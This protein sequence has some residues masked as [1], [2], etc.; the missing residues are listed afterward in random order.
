M[1]RAEI[2]LRPNVP[3]AAIERTPLSVSQRKSRMESQGP[4]PGHGGKADFGSDLDC[5]AGASEPKK[6]LASGETFL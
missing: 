1:E 2:P 3:P 6:V 5:L 4:L